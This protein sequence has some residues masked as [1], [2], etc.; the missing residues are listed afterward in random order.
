MK[1]ILKNCIPTILALMMNGFYAIMDGFF[2]GKSTG[3]IGLAAINLAWPI[4]ALIIATG[5]GLG[6]GGSILYSQ[7]LGKGQIDN[8][9]RVLT[10]TIC[11]LFTIG[12]GLMLI[13][14]FSFPV[15]LKVLGAEGEVYIQAYAYL[16]VIV[17]GCVFQVLGTGFIPILRNLGMPLQAMITSCSGII[18]NLILNYI[19]IM[20]MDMGIKG[21][22]Y[23]TVLAQ[24]VVISFTIILILIDRRK[25][26]ISKVNGKN[27]TLAIGEITRETLIRSIAPFGLSLAPSLVLIFS[28]YRCL[29]YGGAEAVACYAVISYITFPIQSMLMGVGE[30]LQPLMSFQYGAHKTADLE[31][32][33]KIGKKI[34]AILAISFTVILLLLADYIAGFFGISEV[35]TSYFGTGIRI[36]AVAFIFI[37]ILKFRIS[38]ENATGNSKRAMIYTYLESCFIAPICI[39]LLSYLLGINGVWISFV[40]TNIVM[41]IIV[42]VVKE[43]KIKIGGN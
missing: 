22:A 41:C 2:I 19:F 43:N 27:I 12:V 32:I 36:S 18:V 42:L 8:S 9:K 29:K 38:V 17:L 13:L 24:G 23:G 28:N 33:I 10:T 26:R 1:V 15:I 40:M 4:P 5:I 3:D 11:L 30:G 35:A 39:Y 21:A 7:E 20:R 37:G 34:S 16:K 6:I 31:N 14:R 25:E